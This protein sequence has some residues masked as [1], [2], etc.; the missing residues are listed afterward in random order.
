[1]EKRE[2]TEE[3]QKRKRWSWRW[4]TE[5]LEVSS[6]LPVVEEEGERMRKQ[7]LP[8]FAVRG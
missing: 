8:R 6:V 5:G 2:R 7:A 1:M 3:Q 4:M